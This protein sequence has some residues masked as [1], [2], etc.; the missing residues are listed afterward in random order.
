MKA[1]ADVVKRRRCKQG[2]QVSSSGETS[3]GDQIAGLETASFCNT[4]LHF[5]MLV[6]SRRQTQ[7]TFDWVCWRS[8]LHTFPNYTQEGESQQKSEAWILPHPQF[9]S[10]WNTCLHSHT[11]THVRADTNASTRHVT[12]IVLEYDINITTCS[13]KTWHLWLLQINRPA[14][15]P[16]VWQQSSLAISKRIL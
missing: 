7:A 5:S 4:H 16:S 9:Y 3:S 14:K 8:L 10:L 12:C 11:Y 15:I 2:G 13:F 1:P 6:S